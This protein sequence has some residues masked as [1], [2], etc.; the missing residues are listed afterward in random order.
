M[1]EEDGNFCLIEPHGGEER[2]RAQGRGIEFP[3]RKGEIWPTNSC[4]AGP[5]APY[6]RRPELR[7]KGRPGEKAGNLIRSRHPVPE[8]RISNFQRLE[9]DFGF[10]LP[11]TTTVECKSGYGLD[12]ETEV[13]ML[14]A[15]ETAK[16]RLPI[17]VSST[18]CGAHAVPK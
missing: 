14:L 4:N 12:T 2:E 3:L 18:F 7:W 15:L 1:R 8:R 10:F 5:K 9:H 17:E 13:K 11:G 6:T 16:A